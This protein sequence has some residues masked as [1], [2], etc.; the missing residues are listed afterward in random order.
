MAQPP[1]QAFL[2]VGDIQ[3]T[4]DRTT[5][6][7]KDSGTASASTTTPTDPFDL[8]GTRL[9]DI[10]GT[11]DEVIAVSQ[12]FGERRL[13]LG[14]NATETAFKAE[15]L[16]DFEIIHIAAHG[17]ASAKFPDRAGLALG[18]DPKSGE[19]GLLQVR[20]IRDLNL[21]A[22]LVTLSAC[23]TGVG[24]LEGEEGIANLVRAFLFAGA[25]SVVASLWAASDVYTLNLMEHFYR[26]IAAGVDKGSA[27]R[28]AQLDLIKQFADQALPFYWAGFI[29]VGD[30]SRNIRLSLNGAQVGY[31]LTKTNSCHRKEPGASQDKSRSF[32]THGVP[33][34]RRG[35]NSCRRI[36]KALSLGRNEELGSRILR[37]AVLTAGGGA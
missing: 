12:L 9:Q 35:Q 36:Q 4:Q 14:T 8:A 3:L 5:A 25:K 26:Y 29:M 17:I 23:D 10:P 18:N 1:T 30:G 20:E 32:I 22:D 24:A 34:N 21:A 2:G 7:K 31:S 13:L 27:L 33:T 19:D 15:P 6:T 11:R 28:H 37:P 16:A